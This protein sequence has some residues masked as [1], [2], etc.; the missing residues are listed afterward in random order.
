MTTSSL[1]KEL[2]QRV[3]LPLERIE[4]GCARSVALDKG[5]M[6]EFVWLAEVPALCLAL[7]VGQVMGLAKDECLACLPACEPLLES[8]SPP[9]FAI[10]QRQDTLY[11]CQTLMGGAPAA[12][13]VRR[14]LDGLAQLALQ[15]R[16]RLQAQQALA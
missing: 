5:L 2:A 13:S 4:D 9:H 12:Q 14:V 8:G 7:P 15:A 10:S 3:H 16:I 1:T 11:L 6:L